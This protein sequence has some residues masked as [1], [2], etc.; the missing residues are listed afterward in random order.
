MGIF[1]GNSLVYQRVFFEISLTSWDMVL[2][3]FCRDLI[4]MPN[5]PGAHK[6]SWILDFCTAHEKQSMCR[7]TQE[8]FAAIA[9]F[10]GSFWR[11]IKPQ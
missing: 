10:D 6:A 7:N 9:K 3:V 4:L 11:M 5:H 8:V 2:I 1:M